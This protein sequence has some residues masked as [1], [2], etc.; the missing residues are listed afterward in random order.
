MTEE[1]ELQAPE[2]EPGRPSEAELR[3]T[4]SYQKHRLVVVG[5]F[6]VAIVICGFSFGPLG[7]A[8]GAV[9]TSIFDSM[10]ASGTAGKSAGLSIMLGANAAGFV[11]AL[12]MSL[13][14]G[15]R[16]PSGFP[17]VVIGIIVPLTLASMQA[18]LFS[19]TDGA[20]GLENTEFARWSFV[21]MF[22]LTLVTVEAGVTIGRRRLEKREA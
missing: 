9:A 11:F 14:I 21:V 13:F 4:A 22:V 15:P 12:L 1:N 10:V 20:G 18:T 5:S 6:L 17:H 19:L 7:E 16:V 8:L 2:R 3:R